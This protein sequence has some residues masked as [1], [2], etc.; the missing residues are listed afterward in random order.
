M[1]QR[2]GGQVAVVQLL[3][4]AHQLQIGLH[5][6]QALIFFRVDDHP[7]GLAAAGDGDGALMQLL[8]QNR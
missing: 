2:G 5:L 3:G 7:D 4:E 1:N 6:A 8:E